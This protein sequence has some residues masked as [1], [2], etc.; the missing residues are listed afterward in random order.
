MNQELAANVIDYRHRK[1][2]FKSL[3]QLVKVKGISH[4]RLGAIRSLLSIE[5][6]GMEFIN[7]INSLHVI[8]KLI[9]YTLDGAINLSGPKVAPSKFQNGFAT[10]RH[11]KSTS[12]P[13]QMCLEV[14][15]G[16]S[17][18][19]YDDIFDLLGAYSH[20]PVIKDDFTYVP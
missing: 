17:N 12:M 13:I 3:D 18:A 20:R 8:H 4:G 10:P 9:I 14:S 5:D 16:F 7:K 19:P 2:A 11:R 1:G 15:N 6:D